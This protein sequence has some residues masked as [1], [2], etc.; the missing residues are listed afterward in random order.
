MD[1]TFIRFAAGQPDATDD[2][3][4][5]QIK[6]LSGIDFPPETKENWLRLLSSAGFPQ[7][8]A[9]S[10]FRKLGY[11]GYEDADELPHSYVSNAARS[12]DGQVVPIDEPLMLT[13]RILAGL[14]ARRGR[15]QKVSDEHSPDGPFDPYGF[16][17]D[18][19]EYH[20]L[21][22]I[23]WRLLAFLWRQEKRSARFDELAEPV[24]QD[25]TEAVDSRNFGSS[26]RDVN[27]WLKSKSIPLRVRS[28]SNIAFLDEN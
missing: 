12:E 22:Q 3:Y 7:G 17:W 16:R 27:R 18:G 8:L 26:R 6:E 4:A 2:D 13:Q 15:D 10:V 21:A 9:D 11:R 20:G 19:Q 5:Q 14:E 24:W 25:R 23:P 28:K 1:S